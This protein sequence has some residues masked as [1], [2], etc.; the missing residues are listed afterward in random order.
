MAGLIIYFL[1]G[2]GMHPRQEDTKES[3][4]PMGT[5]LISSGKRNHFWKSRYLGIIQCY[6]FAQIY[7]QSLWH[8]HSIIRGHG[9]INKTCSVA[10]RS[11][12][13]D[14]GYHYFLFKIFRKACGIPY[15]QAKYKITYLHRI[16]CKAYDILIQSQED[17]EESTKSV[18]LWSH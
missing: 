3:V 5:L 2:N 16:I 17:I 11:I 7:P 15:V 8:L 9:G 14:T 10:W 18:L 13:A 4:G 1:I 12:D 6:F